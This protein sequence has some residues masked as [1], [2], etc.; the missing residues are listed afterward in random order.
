M[1]GGFLVPVSSPVTIFFAPHTCTDLQS[2]GSCIKPD[3]LL[4]RAT[5]ESNILMHTLH[6]G[7]ADR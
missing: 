5:S 6:A 1:P 3:K 7:W 4:L 2:Q